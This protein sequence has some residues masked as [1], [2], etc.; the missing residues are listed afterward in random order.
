MPVKNSP[1]AGVFVAVWVEGLIVEDATILA[2]AC[3]NFLDN[4]I[5]SAFVFGVGVPVSIWLKVEVSLA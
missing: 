3:S 2:S 4:V 1:F 5:F